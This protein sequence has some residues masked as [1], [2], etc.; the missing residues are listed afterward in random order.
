MEDKIND[1]LWKYVRKALLIVIY[2][3]FVV[4]MILIYVAIYSNVDI[5]IIMLA[6]VALLIIYFGYYRLMEEMHDIAKEITELK[7]NNQ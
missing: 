2:P 7:E 6:N 3:L 4:T 1:I 5:T